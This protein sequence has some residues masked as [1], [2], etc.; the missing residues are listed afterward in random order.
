MYISADER[1]SNAAQKKEANVKEQRD[2][3]TNELR[4]LQ[5]FIV[6]ASWYP[7]N[8]WWEEG[9]IVF[10]GRSCMPGNSWVLG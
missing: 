3:R 4:Y 8:R 9:G 6:P 1:F 2:V 10:L 5:D 7:K